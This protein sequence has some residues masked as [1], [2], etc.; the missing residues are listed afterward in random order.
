MDRILVHGHLPRFVTVGIVTSP[1]QCVQPIVIDPNGGQ[2]WKFGTL[3]EHPLGK[4]EATCHS[5]SLYS[6]MHGRLVDNN[7]LV[8]VEEICAVDLQFGHNILLVLD[9]QAFVTF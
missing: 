7:Q 1:L 4:G 8:V 2:L 5:P 9:L 3:W 6:F